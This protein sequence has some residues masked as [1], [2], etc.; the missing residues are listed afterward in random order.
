MR[1][2]P[3]TSA[4]ARLVVEAGGSAE[5][6]AEAMSHLDSLELVFMRQRLTE[7]TGARDNACPY[8]IILVIILTNNSYSKHNLIIIIVT[9]VRL[10]VIIGITLALATMLEGFL[11]SAKALAA[12]AEAKAVG[13]EEKRGTRKVGDGC[14]SAPRRRRAKRSLVLVR[15]SV[16]FPQAWVI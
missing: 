16:G 15:K 4:K 12:A 7:S 14:G 6:P 2:R 3:H 1:I 10:I 5:D 11:A 13:K 8:L 9:I